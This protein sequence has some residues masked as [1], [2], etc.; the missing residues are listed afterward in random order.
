MTVNGPRWAA[1]GGTWHAPGGG[2]LRWHCHKRRTARSAPPDR[3]CWLPPGDGSARALRRRRAALPQRPGRLLAD[4]RQ[5]PHGRTAAHER[6]PAP[7]IAELPE[8]EPLLAPG[9]SRIE[10]PPLSRQMMREGPVDY[11]L[12]TGRLARLLGR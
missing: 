1:W 10:A 3:W 12:L 11:H 2:A 6:A 9:A 4:L 8:S 7:V 5:L